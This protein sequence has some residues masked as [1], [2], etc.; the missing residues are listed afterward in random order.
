MKK[1]LVI[2]QAMILAQIRREM[3]KPSFPFKNKKVY[4]RKVSPV[5]GY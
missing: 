5:Y 4:S 3:P 1:P 2:N